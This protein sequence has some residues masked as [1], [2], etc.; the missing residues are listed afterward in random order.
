MSDRQPNPPKQKTPK[1]AEIPIPKRKE[2]EV[3]LDAAAKPVKKQS[4]V[5]R[6]KK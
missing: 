3:V 2:F 1:G 6:P 4:G 5:R